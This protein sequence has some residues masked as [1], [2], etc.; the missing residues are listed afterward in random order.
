ME[1]KNL[2]NVGYVEGVVD[3]DL[4]EKIKNTV[5]IIK[6]NFDQQRSF[7]SNLVGNIRHEYIFDHYREE[8]EQLAIKLSQYHDDVYDCSNFLDDSYGK[9][10]LGALWINF[11][12]PGEFNPVHKHPGVYSFV[13][14]I[15]IPFNYEDEK[16]QGPGANSNSNKAGSFEFV[17]TNVYGQLM[18]HQIPADNTYEG[19]VILFPAKLNHTVYPF[20]TSTGYRI[21]LSGNLFRSPESK[22]SLR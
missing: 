10:S 8:I 6:G 9:L 5:E 14:W 12:S 19:K 4:M 3:A 21:S 20:F 13:I 1:E 11:Q 16:N 15:E 2:K 22:A 18:G 7:S 17:Y